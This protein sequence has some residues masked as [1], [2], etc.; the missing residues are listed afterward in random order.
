MPQAKMLLLVVPVD[1][2]YQKETSQMHLEQVL[3]GEETNLTSSCFT[4]WGKV[5]TEEAMEIK[6]KNVKEATETS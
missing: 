3:C 2:C 5:K 4:R 1:V 6:Q